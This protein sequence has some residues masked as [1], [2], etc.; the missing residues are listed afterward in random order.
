VHLPKRAAGSNARLVK[1]KENGFVYWK[2]K[3]IE[4][5]AKTPGH[6]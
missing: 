3:R 2:N 1:L 6:E 4:K 5:D